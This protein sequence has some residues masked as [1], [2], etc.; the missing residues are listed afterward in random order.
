MIDG[1]VDME[2]NPFCEDELARE[3]EEMMVAEVLCNLRVVEEEADKDDGD[4]ATI[5]EVRPQVAATFDIINKLA[6]Q[7]KSLAV[8]I[9]GL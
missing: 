2:S 5:A 4:N 8:E 3:V 9:E 6:T 7:L 1:W